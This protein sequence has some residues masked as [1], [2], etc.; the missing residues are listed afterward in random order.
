M[1]AARQPLQQ[2]C[3][4][5][6]VASRHLAVIIIFIEKLAREKK[7]GLTTNQR[8]AKQRQTDY[9]ITVFT[10]IPFDAMGQGWQHVA[11]GQRVVL[12]TF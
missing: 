10:I 11:R 6:A 9:S 3:Q 8:C 7:K 5:R 2:Y 1:N 4:L 12:T